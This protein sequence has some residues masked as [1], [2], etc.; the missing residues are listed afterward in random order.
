MKNDSTVKHTM[1]K[2]RTLKQIIHSLFFIMFRNYAMVVVAFAILTGLIFVQL[3]SRSA[4]EANKDLLIKQAESIAKRVSVFVD[5]EDYITYPSFLEVL[6]EL[7]TTDIWI[8]ANPKSPILG[9]DFSKK[10]LLGFIS[11]CIKLSFLFA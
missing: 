7:E 8:I 4:I 2:K 9:I 10:I 6:E 11:R 5:D 1:V 3:Y